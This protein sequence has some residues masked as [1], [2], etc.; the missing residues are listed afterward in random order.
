MVYRAVNVGAGGNGMWLRAPR[1]V[2]RTFAEYRDAVQRSTDAVT[3]GGEAPALQRKPNEKAARVGGT[4]VSATVTAATA[5]GGT[6]LPPAVRHF[7]EPRFGAD[8]GDVRV[9]TGA[10]A[11]VSARSL[12]AR[13]YT[14]GRDIV[15]SAGEYA[16]DTHA[17]R[18]L[19]AHELAH[20]L[21]Q[22]GTA[23][24]TVQRTPRVA[25]MDWLVSHGDVASGNAID[26]IAVAI[27]ALGLSAADARQQ[28]QNAAARAHWAAKR[29]LYVRAF[30]FLRDN[31]ARFDVP[32]TLDLVQRV[33]DYCDASAATVATLND[34]FYANLLVTTVYSAGA[35]TAT[36]THS[37]GT[38]YNVPG[39]AS[40][41]TDFAPSGD[42][43]LLRPNPDRGGAGPGPG[44]SV[45]G[46]FSATTDLLVAYGA[47][48][49]GVAAGSVST[50]LGAYSSQVPQRLRPFVEALA[51]DPTIF[52]V[53]QRF[54]HDDRGAFHLQHVG[55]GGAHYTPGRPASIEVDPD[56]FP[57]SRA[58]R[59]MTD[60]GVRATLAHELYHYALDRADTALTEVGGSSDHNLISVIQDRYTIVALLRGGQSPVANEVHAL[61]G[62]VG[63]DPKP[64]L[65]RFIANNDQAGLRAYVQTQDFLDSTVYTLLVTPIS[66]L[67]GRLSGSLGHV[68][69]FLLD[70]SQITD[71][72]YLAAI[73]G[74]ILRK[75]FEI[76]ADVSARTRTPLASI[77]NNATYQTEIR[78]FIARF[79][80]LAS[81]NRAQGAAA[82]AAT[83]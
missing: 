42:N 56:I 28:A 18:R 49:G 55:Y 46:G 82:L 57:G 35:G 21:Q 4:D 64:A 79:I 7:F 41:S 75:A 51:T 6:P 74:V 71:L 16:P 2:Q 40:G 27:A 65:A 5:A 25:N 61:E 80:G 47:Q 13:A 9:H 8:F 39:R 50:M 81:Q 12:D 22:S 69:D 58:S 10:A 48:Q 68:S 73:N 31:R 23:R 44:R 59:E 26:L 1:D 76:A 45:T 43:S 15:F 3:E 62:F 70:P 67:A 14:L 33:L 30:D 32:N 54:L 36:F 52:S 72:A 34:A 60:I 11:T 38:T 29:D 53:L 77:W 37:S 24:P 19:I 83:V 17:G 20:T 78:S 66:G 63:G